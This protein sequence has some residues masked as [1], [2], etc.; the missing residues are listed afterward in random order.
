LGHRLRGVSRT[1]L[2][3]VFAGTACETIMRHGVKRMGHADPTPPAERLNRLRQ[4][5]LKLSFQSHLV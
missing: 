4:A 1:V 3:P 5:E 2:N